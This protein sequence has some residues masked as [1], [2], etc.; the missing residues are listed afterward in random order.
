MASSSDEGEIM[1]N[2]AVD[3]KATSLPKKFEGN[4]VDRQDRTRDRRSASNSPEYDS[5]ARNNYH[6]SRRSRSPP[7][8]RGFKRARDERDYAGG[9]RQETRR[10]RVHYEDGARD[11][12]R[13]SRVSYEDL[14]RPPSRG[15]NTS[16][17]GRDRNRSRERDAYRDRD[18]ERDRER[19]RYPDKRQRNRTRSPYRPPRGERGGR[20]D[21]YARDGGR[22]RLTDS[23]RGLKYDDNRD[24]N[25]RNGGAAPNGVA[26]G[27]DSRASRQD[28]KPVKDSADRE[29]SAASRSRGQASV[30]PPPSKRTRFLLTPDDSAPQVVEP[31]HSYDEP[32]EPMVIDE[33]AEIERRRRRRDE[34]LA[35]SSSATPLLIHALHATDKSAIPSPARES[36]P[37]ADI[38]TPGTGKNLVLQSLTEAKFADIASPARDGSSPGAIDIV[39]ESDL[40]NTHGGGDAM[41]E[42]GPSAAD[43]D[44]TADMKEDERRDELRHGNVGVHGEAPDTKHETQ[45]QDQPQEAPAKKSSE[46][47]DDDD[48]FDMFA[49]DFDDEKYAAPNPVKVAVV[50]E[51]KASP[52]LAPTNGAIL[53]GDDKDGYYK[54]RIGEILNGRYQVQSALGKGMFSGVARAVDITNK[55]LV[56]VKIM[57]NN[58][59]L[60]KGGFTEIAILQKL[61][62]ADPENRKHIVKFERHFDHK[63]HLCMA[64]E[65]LSLNLREVLKKFGNNVGINLSATRAYAHQ[66]FIGLAHMRK[67]SVIHAD[68]KPDNI[69]VNESRNVLKICDLGTGIDKSDAATAHNEITPYLVSRFY[70]APEIILG[71]PY[72]YS[73]DMWSIGA[74]LYELYTGKILFAGDSNNQM[75]KAI[76]EIRGKI[77][78]KLYKRGQ[79]SAMHFDEM[80]NFVS[81]ER[82]KALGKSCY[83]GR[84]GPEMGLVEAE[85][86][87]MRA[88]RQSRPSACPGTLASRCRP[89]DGLVVVDIGPVTILLEANTP[90]CSDSHDLLGW[91]GIPVWKARERILPSSE[92]ELSQGL[93][94]TAASSQLRSI[95]SFPYIPLFFCL[96][97]T[98]CVLHKGSNVSGRFTTARV[99]P[100]VK[101]TRDLR[102]RLFAASAGMNDAETR[103]LNHFV[104]LLEHCLTLNPEKRIKPADALKHP[105]FTAKAAAPVKR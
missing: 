42:D 54:L 46:D 80:G 20:D 91:N 75:L 88:V 24:R 7:P 90:D 4:G 73:I 18:R 92:D 100:V 52:A 102:T 33:E 61:N 56:A 93:F 27:M 11:D 19:D 74:T 39:N 6:F 30:S 69:L 5:S 84:R 37:T 10:F 68:L 47:D 14:D 17:D 45:P 96:S 53:E 65:N 70:R 99:L 35:K 13:R 105:F 2:D 87:S 86:G 48:D 44:P 72:D 81:M 82:D 101:P 51:S 55:K 34:L 95:S 49:E 28:A 78:P 8:P 23:F 59:A 76:M 9:G 98:P 31:D 36:T 22:D 94:V 16:Y 43:Y 104:D 62:D 58:D 77:T 64:F 89:A 40:M 41:E 1:E 29:N 12:Y 71:M 25:A 85:C 60:R 50:D 67:C 32:E 79:L 83:F 63:G 66:I 26:V 97:A 15:S 57:R 3:L 103:D 21:H 38:G